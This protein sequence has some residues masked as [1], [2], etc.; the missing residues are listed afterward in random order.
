MFA[1]ASKTK[2]KL[3][4]ISHRSSSATSLS[5]QIHPPPSWRRPSTPEQSSLN[6]V[7]AFSPDTP[8]EIPDSGYVTQHS[9]HSSEES[10]DYREEDYADCALDVRGCSEPPM[11]GGISFPSVMFGEKPPDTRSRPAASSKKPASSSSEGEKRVQMRTPSPISAK[12]VDQETLEKWWDYEW[13]LDQLEGSIKDFPK[14]ML[15]LTSPVIILLRQ[16]HEKALIRPFRKIFPG[17][18]DKLLGY[19]CAALIARNYLVSMAS[20]HHRRNNSLTQPPNNLSRLDSVPEKARATLGITLPSASRFQVAERLMG[21]RSQ[22]LRKGLDRILDKL[23]FT[24]CGRADETLKAAVTVLIQV[25]ESKA[26][27]S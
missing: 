16:N 4:D 2:P 23:I 1:V 26:Q 9:N 17:V 27:T 3:V 20:T 21:S 14:S 5:V 8:Q 18:P 22:E 11:T 12:T 6:E 13:T 10:Q 25:L 7:S 15:Q 19:L 24:I